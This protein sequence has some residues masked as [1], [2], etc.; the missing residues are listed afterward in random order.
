MIFVVPR[1]FVQ[2]L[3]SNIIMTANAY[4]RFPA[5]TGIGSPLGFVGCL[6]PPERPQDGSRQAFTVINRKPAACC[7]L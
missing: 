1:P 5:L 6:I 7:R 2:R 3:L 4:R